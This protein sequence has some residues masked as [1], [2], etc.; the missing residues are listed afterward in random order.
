MLVEHPH[1]PHITANGG[2]L[3]RMSQGVFT[4]P[5]VSVHPPMSAQ[6]NAVVTSSQGKEGPL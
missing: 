5:W 3:L 2:V 6:Q 1:K 4:I